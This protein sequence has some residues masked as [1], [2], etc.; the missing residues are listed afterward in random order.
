LFDICK[1]IER[2]GS[3]LEDQVKKGL[4]VEVQATEAEKSSQEL[5]RKLQSVSTCYNMK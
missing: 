1:Q 5:S 3:D 2:L 4:S